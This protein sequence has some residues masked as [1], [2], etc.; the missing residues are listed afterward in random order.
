MAKAPTEPVQSIPGGAPKTQTVTTKTRGDAGGIQAMS[1]TLNGLDLLNSTIG[2]GDEEKRYK[3]NMRYEGSSDALASTNAYN[4]YG[5]HTVNDQVVQG[6]TANMGSIQDIGTYMATAAEGGDINIDPSKRGTFKAQA[7]RMD[8]SVQEAA[9]HILANKDQ[10]SPEMIKKANFAKNFAKEQGGDI[11]DFGAYLPQYSQ[12]SDIENYAE[13]G[14]YEL[15]EAQIR[16]IL[17]N[18]GE[19]EFL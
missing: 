8:M 18:G 16:Q 2:A 4:P 1:N 5:F 6:R 19:I 15:T 11:Q 3:E 13:G 9:S 12:G 10:Y 17:A 14:E 7:T